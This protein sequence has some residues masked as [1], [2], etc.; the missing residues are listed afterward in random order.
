[1]TN[2]NTKLGGTPTLQELL[3]TKLQQDELIDQLVQIN[4]CEMF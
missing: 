2:Q 4:V 3:N 1:M